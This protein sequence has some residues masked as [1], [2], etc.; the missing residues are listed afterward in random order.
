MVSELDEC[1][2]LWPRPYVP[3]STY[4]DSTGCTGIGSD[5]PLDVGLFRSTKAGVVVFLFHHSSMLEC[6]L[7]G[8]LGGVPSKIN[9]IGHGSGEKKF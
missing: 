9:G 7:L 8:N 6:C 5:G 2:A 3:I 1:V 4:L